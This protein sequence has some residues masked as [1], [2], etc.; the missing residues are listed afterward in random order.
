[1]SKNIKT[2]DRFIKI[3]LNR[4]LLQDSTSQKK[5]VRKKSSNT[6][7]PSKPDDRYPARRKVAGEASF[8]FIDIGLN[9]NGTDWQFEQKLNL[10]GSIPESNTTR[11]TVPFSEWARFTREVILRYQ[12]GNFKKIDYL[13]APS[14]CS[15]LLTYSAVGNGKGYALRPETDTINEYTIA[16]KDTNYGKPVPY[17]QA[18]LQALKT[19]WKEPGILKFEKSDD[20]K[21][22]IRFNSLVFA[23]F[24]TGDSANFKITRTPD[25]TADPVSYNPLAG[26]TEVF[27]VPNLFIEQIA[28]TIVA[29]PDPGTQTRFYGELIA[30][31]VPRK[32][33][34]EAQQHSSDCRITATS[35]DD[36]EGHFVDSLL[37]TFT[38][39]DKPLLLNSENVLRGDFNR[40]YQAS[41]DGMGTVIPASL[42][43]LT[44]WKIASPTGPE[45]NINRAIDYSTGPKEQNVFFGIFGPTI[46]S[47]Q[48]ISNLGTIYPAQGTICAIL[49]QANKE[50]YVWNKTTG[51]HIQLTAR[52]SIFRSNVGYWKFL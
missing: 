3:T 8:E 24:D 51:S 52:K 7:R 10:P 45:F 49:K 34:D 17:P 2:N 30:V 32:F 36:G 35:Y 16:D 4:S 31:P 44:S 20:F 50:Y 11:L 22:K 46:V 39:L 28:E 19:K 26:K 42:S 12:N 37:A 13:M 47:Y 6:A 43:N 48:N 21:S 40:V 5:L 9:P 23:V 33:L 15:Y 27:C 18:V 38:D 41:Y 25:F 1:M 29:Y 14:Y